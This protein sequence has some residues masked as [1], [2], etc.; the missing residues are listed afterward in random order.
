MQIYIYLKCMCMYMCKVREKLM[1]EYVKK[2]VCKRE[3]MRVS[4]K[5]E[6]V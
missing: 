1:F 6:S 4:Y 2:R 3:K 5:R